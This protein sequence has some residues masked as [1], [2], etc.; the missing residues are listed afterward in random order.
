VRVPEDVGFF[1]INVSERSQ[2]C[3]GL[4]LLPQ[5]LGA[6]AVETVVGMLHRREQGV[7]R[8]PNSISIDA[9]FT[10]GPTLRPT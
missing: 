8:F 1:R 9:L 10:D 3:A 4:D 5:R 6:T 2:P 7:P